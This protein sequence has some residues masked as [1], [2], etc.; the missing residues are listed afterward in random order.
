MT[1]YQFFEYILIASFGVSIVVFTA[2]F[3][4]SAPYGRHSRRGWGPM[5]PNRLGWLLMETLSPVAMLILFIIGTAPKTLPLIIFLL[6]WQAHY[7]HRAFIYPFM[8]ADGQK[9]MP[10]SIAVMGLVFNTGNGYLN[11]RYLF[12]FSGGYETDWLWSPQFIVGAAIFVLGFVINR[13]ADEVLRK[14]RAPGERDYKIPYGGLYR[15]I[16]CPNYFGEIIEWF[17]WA[18]ATWS[19]PGLSFALW[20]YVNLAPR[21]RAHH[22]W[23]QENF[24]EY[25][26]ERKALV[27]GLW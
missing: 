22:K 20:T 19:I 8:I 4:V 26:A 5:L 13:W 14:L 7:F 6:M 27:P 23:Y 11:G 21:A 16:S 25:P 24:P 3:F 18:I 10:L 2:L 17:G 9:R 1:E 15:W 12:S